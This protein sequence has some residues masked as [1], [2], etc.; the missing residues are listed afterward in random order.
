MHSLTS[1]GVPHEPQAAGHI[2]IPVL[3]LSLQERL[4]LS[5]H[6]LGPGSC[7]IT[8]VTCLLGLNTQRPVFL[9]TTTYNS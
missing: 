3:L 1:C 5:Q 8:Y 6:L 9:T 2:S 4:E 7:L